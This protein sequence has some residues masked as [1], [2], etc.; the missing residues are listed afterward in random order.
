[1]SDNCL[2]IVPI[3]EGDY[4]NAVAKAA[5]IL[6]W[7]QERDIVETEASDCVLSLDKTGYRFKPNIATIF[8]DGEQWAYND[9]HTHGLEIEVGERQVFSP[10]EGM[11]LK[12]T[13]PNCHTQINEDVG[14]KWI[15]NWCEQNETDFPVCPNCKQKRH[16]TAYSIEPE[17]AF[18]NIAISLWNTHWDL[19]PEFI[20]EMEAL[21]G[22][23]VKVVPVRI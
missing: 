13:C 3:H 17:W 22:M 11:Y 19:K 5:E 9:L 23:K 10:M 21:F 4:P 14:F 1:M 6:K 16:L 15:G 2:H 7:F 18:S 8:N 20:E 12:I